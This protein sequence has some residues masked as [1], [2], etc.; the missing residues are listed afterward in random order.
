MDTVRS[1]TAPPGRS[2]SVRR[3]TAGRADDDHPTYRE[4]VFTD[5]APGELPRLSELTDA[6]GPLTAEDTYLDGLR[7]L[8][9]GLTGRG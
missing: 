8:V 4:Q 1:D 2:W 7:A 9:E 3:R 5:L 6:W